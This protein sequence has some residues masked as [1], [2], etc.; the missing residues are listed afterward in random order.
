MREREIFKREVDKTEKGMYANV[1]TGEAGF[2]KEETIEEEE[3]GVRTGAKE[4]LCADEVGEWDVLFIMDVTQLKG[5]EEKGGREKGDRRSGGDCSPV[6][7]GL[8]AADG[9]GSF[10]ARRRLTLEDLAVV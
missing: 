5:G 2:G 7:R 10:I 8:H 3:M 1:G 9:F 6:K 4:L